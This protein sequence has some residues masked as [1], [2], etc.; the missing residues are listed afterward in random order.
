MSKSLYVKIL[1]TRSES[2]GTTGVVTHYGGPH[3]PLARACSS[4]ACR[5]SRVRGQ[6]PRTWLDLWTLPRQFEPYLVA[7][8]SGRLSWCSRV[9]HDRVLHP[10]TVGSA[11]KGKEDSMSQL[12]I[13]EAVGT[14]LRECQTILETVGNEEER[15]ALT[16]LELMLLETYV[17]QVRLVIT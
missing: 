7:H 9:F 2:H 11:H 10:A 4:R 13:S 5:L 17:R 8:G 16:S 6:N 14:L 15:R 3:D 1:Q 12:Q